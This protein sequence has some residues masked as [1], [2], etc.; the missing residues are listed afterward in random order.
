MNLFV[1]CAKIMKKCLYFRFCAQKYKYC[2]ESQKICGDVR[3]HILNFY[4]L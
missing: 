2:D 4:N 1:N 3:P